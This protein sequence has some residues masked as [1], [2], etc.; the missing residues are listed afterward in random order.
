[1]ID[2]EIALGLHDRATRG[3]SL[4][5]DEQA[6]LESGYQQEDAAESARPGAV[7]AESAVLSLHSQVDA[8]LDQLSA[9]IKRMQSVTDENAA[10]SREIWCNP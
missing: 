10:L 6:L 1:M 8:T 4:S 5:A 3:D 2:N 7:S 9:V